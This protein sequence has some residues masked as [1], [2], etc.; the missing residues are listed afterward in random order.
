MGV[1]K[2]ILY[3][4]VQKYCNTLQ[5]ICIDIKSFKL[6]DSNSHLNFHHFIS[7]TATAS[8]IIIPSELREDEIDF[9]MVIG[10][11]PGT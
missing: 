8:I 9:I 4:S 10:I 7:F 11:V 6:R 3:K 2:S 1:Y 5:D